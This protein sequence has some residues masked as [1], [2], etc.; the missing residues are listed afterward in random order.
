[1]GI[2]LEWRFGD[3]LPDERTGEQPGSQRA[4]RRWFPWLLLLLVVAGG[5]YVGWRDRQQNLTRAETQ[6]RQV[7][8]LEFR[9]LADGDAELFLSLQDPADRSWREA[10]TAAIDTAG[11]PL[12]LQ[13]R[14]SS[15]NTTVENARV[16]GDRAQVEIVH[17]ATLSSGN[18]AV[19]RAVRFYRYTD[20]ARWL[21][22]QVT[23][24]AGGHRI[25]FVLDQLRLTACDRD[26]DWV[27]PVAS[28][29]AAA[30]YRFC[31]LVSCRQGLPLELN[32]AA[33]LEEGAAPNTTTLPAPFLIGAPENDAAREMWVESLGQFLVD[34]LMNREIAVRRAGGARGAR[35]DSD[36]HNAI[37]G[38]E[39]GSDDLRSLRYFLEAARWIPTE[40]LW[41][42]LSAPD[43]WDSAASPGPAPLREA[44][45]AE[46]ER[47][48]TTEPTRAPSFPDLPDLTPPPGGWI[49]FMTP[50]EALALI[51]PDGS[52]RIPL[53]AKGSID[54]FQWSPDGRR[55]AFAWNG[56]LVLL[57]IGEA[58]FVPLTSPGAISHRTSSFAWSHDSR[59]LAYLHS[60]DG[61]GYQ[62]VAPDA[63]RVLDVTTREPITVTTYSNTRPK[64]MA[65]LPR[66]PFPFPLLAV[67][68]AGIPSLVNIWD[69]R[70]Q[71]ALTEIYGSH[72]LW[73]PH[74]PAM[75]FIRMD[76]DKPGIE[77]TC[78]E[79]TQSCPEGETQTIHP[80]SLALWRMADGSTG[81][82][83]PMVV[84][85]GTQ[86]Q[87]CYPVAWL[88][89]GRVEVRILHFEKTAYPDAPQPERVTYRH[90][91]LSDEGILQEVAS[92]NLSWW[93][94][95]GF[96]EAFTATE[97]HQEHVE[98]PPRLSIAP[99]GEKAAFTWFSHI[100]E[101]RSP[102]G[103]YVWDGSGEPVPIVAGWDP[104][105][106]PQIPASENR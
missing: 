26:A 50:D 6:V 11:L 79:A 36:D 53:T 52:R 89:D 35:S 97:L 62:P 28:E 98:G 40:R 91:A 68:T 59:H 27:D 63:L 37:R 84:L 23:P 9:A 3:E 32:L 77:W 55:L 10:Q 66:E 56:Q 102:V 20:D 21:H 8:D 104:A 1:M 38:G 16:V 2:D 18:K 94:A 69:I 15:V 87:H 5:T 103:I 47:L 100:D 54:A 12:P 81:S 65:I 25:T 86:R 90:L 61:E 34:R 105:W 88:P 30:A 4:W 70:F 93:T 80:T 24:D 13:D 99:D 75:V 44:P 17:T 42:L 29:L 83:A 46:K 67:K 49:A 92:D 73:L 45:M 60:L 78:A 96:E 48:L 64:E 85:E 57:S 58:R 72:Y 71:T 39:T 51:S 33:S 95:G 41:D 31:R 19:F 14:I 43:A 22:T 101:A 74:A 82:E 106:Q 7:A 76:T